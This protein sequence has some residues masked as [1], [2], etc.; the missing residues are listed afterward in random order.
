MP[1]QPI[2]SDLIA[3]LH[4]AEPGSRALLTGW[5]REPIAR[6]VDRPG[7]IGTLGAD[8]PIEGVDS[9]SQIAAS[10]E[11]RQ[12][13]RV[14][15]PGQVRIIRLDRAPTPFDV[16]ATPGTGQTVASLSCLDSRR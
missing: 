14:R 13:P 16:A 10:P 8:S 12:N 6:L 2:A 15:S 4:R 11:R 5:Y 9:I 3:G 7:P 1:S